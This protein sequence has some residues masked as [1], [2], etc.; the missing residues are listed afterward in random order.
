MRARFKAACALQSR[1]M[2][3]VLEELIM[4]WLKEHEPASLPAPTKPPATAKTKAKRKGSA[5]DAS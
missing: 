2:S 3:E 4:Q 1:D 5:K